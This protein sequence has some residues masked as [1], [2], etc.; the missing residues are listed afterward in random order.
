M[1]ASHHDLPA[2]T[3]ICA[4]DALHSVERKNLIAWLKPAST[5]LEAA[6]IDITDP[7]KDTIDCAAIAKALN[8]LIK[9][10]V[11]DLTGLLYS[12]WESLWVIGGLCNP[13]LLPEV[14]DSLGVEGMRLEQQGSPAPADAAVRLWLA[15]RKRA[16]HLYNLH[17]SEEKWHHPVDEEALED[18]GR[19]AAEKV[20]RLG[21]IRAFV[22]WRKT[23]DYLKR[24]HSIVDDTKAIILQAKIERIREWFEDL[25][26]WRDLRPKTKDLTLDDHKTHAKHQEEIE[27]FI[28]LRRDKMHPPIEYDEV[29]NGHRV[30]HEGTEHEDVEYNW[31]FFR[32]GVSQ[33]ILRTAGVN[34]LASHRDPL[35]RQYFKNTPPVSYAIL[36]RDGIFE[37]WVFFP[38][39]DSYSFDPWFGDEN[40]FYPKELF[41]AG[42]YELR[43][44]EKKGITLESV[45]ADVRETKEIASRL[46]GPIANVERNQ[47]TVLKHVQGVPHL[48]ADLAEAKRFPTDLAADIHSLNA[49]ILTP[50]QQSI[51]H[52]MRR[53]GGSQKGALPS[54][55]R[56]GIVRSAPTLCRKVAEI[57]AILVANKLLPCNAPATPVRYH[58][59]GGYRDVDGNPVAEEIYKPD[60]DWADDQASRDKLIR[61]YLMASAE[62]QKFFRQEYFGIEDEAN[63]YK[64]RIGMKSD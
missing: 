10:N 45:H 4:E 24:C 19:E 8:E 49:D 15:D 23:A 3:I 25:G 43:K 59:S 61:D 42:D 41:Q 39:G 9:V 21:A 44:V 58:R 60:R 26:H 11:K 2:W 51:W 20:I 48:Q 38:N 5:Y 37:G 40:R 62:D 31:E 64:K 17:Y 22:H 33:L 36:E 56:E 47:V 16:I 46:P 18:I 28:D 13:L 63:R 54:L 50:K 57:N 7:T 6:G 12:V 27:D 14:I 30:L 29:R 35:K 32:D 53:A 1:K 52:A 55:R 34:V